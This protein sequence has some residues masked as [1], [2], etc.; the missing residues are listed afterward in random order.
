MQGVIIETH[1][2]WSLVWVELD[3]LPR[4]CT[5]RRFWFGSDRVEVVR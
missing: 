2:R 4:D 3:E 1:P 5:S